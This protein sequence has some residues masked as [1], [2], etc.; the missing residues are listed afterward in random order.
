MFEAVLFDMDGIIADT[1]RFHYIT[2]KKLASEFNIE[3]DEEFNEQLKG[4]DRK[5]SLEKILK[6][7]NIKLTEEEVMH[8][9]DKKNQEYVALLNTLTKADILEGIE[10][11][12]KDLKSANIRIAIA[13]ISR[14]A[15][16]VLEKLGLSE[17]VDAIAN[18]AEVKNSKPAPD[19]FIE[20]ARL[21]DTDI[22]KCIG[23][24]DSQAGIESINSAGIISVGVG[25]LKSANYLA[26]C[27]SELN[28]ELLKQI[29]K[30]E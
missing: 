14:N 19:I 16:L 13:S 5:K 26:N 8:Y 11:L 10:D 1:A 3:I 9:C 17:Y 15:P 28:F 6:L 2:W 30:G 7:G 29:Y 23:I 27:T 24:E 12:L 18:P 25:N 21:V 22:S 4:V 20:A